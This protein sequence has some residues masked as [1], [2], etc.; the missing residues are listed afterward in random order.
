MMLE[1]F[2][3]FG[4]TALAMTMSVMLGITCGLVI[5]KYREY[6]YFRIFKD[7]DKE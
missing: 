4:I 6:R 2:K 5:A 7:K 3:V 1:F